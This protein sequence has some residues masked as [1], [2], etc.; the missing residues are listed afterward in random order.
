MP[1]I[2]N[3]KQD[4]V[5]NTITLPYNLILHR[6]D[7]R[8]DFP[9]P[10]DMTFK[11]YDIVYLIIQES[12]ATIEVLWGPYNSQRYKYLKRITMC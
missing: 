9:L 5:A 8:I 6:T 4:A 10:A 3:G 7:N 12:L 11:Q 1:T 2:N